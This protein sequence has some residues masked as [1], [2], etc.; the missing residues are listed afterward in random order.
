MV[1]ESTMM[2]GLGESGGIPFTSTVSAAAVTTVA[3]EVVVVVVVVVVLLLLSLLLLRVSYYSQLYLLAPLVNIIFFST[4]NY[5]TASFHPFIM[6]ANLK[7][8]SIKGMS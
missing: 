1:E 4:I 3:V 2:L 5:I 7:E 8:R 6:L